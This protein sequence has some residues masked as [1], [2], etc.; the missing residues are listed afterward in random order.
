MCVCLLRCLNFCIANTHTHRHYHTNYFPYS[1]FSLFPLLQQKLKNSNYYVNFGKAKRGGRERKS[2]AAAA[3]NSSNGGG[4]HQ[5]ASNKGLA[6]ITLESNRCNKTLISHAA[7]N[8]AADAYHQRYNYCFSGKS[9]CL[10]EHHHHHH[11]FIITV[12]G[13]TTSTTEPPGTLPS[14]A[15]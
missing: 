15:G 8:K 10:D 4:Q 5:N 14:T 1:P 11:H 3:V 7:A 13:Q 9:F 12:N 6:K 2:A